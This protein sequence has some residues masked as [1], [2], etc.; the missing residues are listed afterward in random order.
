M[1]SR[2]LEEVAR[3]GSSILERDFRRC[4]A[5]QPVPAPRRRGPASSA[6]R[7]PLQLS[8]SGVSTYREC[9]RQYWYRHVQGLPAAPSPE[10]QQGTILHLVLRRLGEYRKAGEPITPE[11]VRTTH[12]EAWRQADFC[13]PRRRPALEAIGLAQVLDYVAAGGFT[14]APAM[15][16]Q[17]FTAGLDGWRL[18][19]I[20]DRIDPPPTRGGG[21]EERSAAWR[22]IDYKTGSP[23]PASQ[24]RRDLQL[25]LYALGARQALGLHPLELEIVYLKGDK[26][27]LLP[28]GDELLAEAEEIGA[29]VADAVAA[30]RFEPRPERRRCRLCAYRL[31]CAEAL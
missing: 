2:F 19:G 25:A 24:L 22:V 8:F 28:A 31:A 21:R 15:V 27:L 23:V 14:D 13:D 4:G 12:A 6:S 26:R 7:E 20:I 29:T 11:L 17:P 5:G 18:R 10:A 30:G 1:P 9:P 16:E 3:A